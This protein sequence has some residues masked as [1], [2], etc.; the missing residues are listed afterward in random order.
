VF[1]NLQTFLHEQR[2]EIQ[3]K[4]CVGIGINGIAFVSS[5]SRNRIASCWKAKE[6]AVRVRKFAESV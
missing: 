5:Q 2:L 4:G 1:A 3:G 6:K